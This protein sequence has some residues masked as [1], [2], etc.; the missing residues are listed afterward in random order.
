VSDVKK[1]VPL[2]LNDLQAI[3]SDQIE[4][5]RDGSASPAQSAA[6]GNLTGKLLLSIRMQQEYAR[7]TGRSVINPLLESGEDSPE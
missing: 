1:I 3:L 7:L 5:A 6:I 4:R 2:N